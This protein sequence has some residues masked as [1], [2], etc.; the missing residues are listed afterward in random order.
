MKKFLSMALATAMTM[1]MASVAFAAETTLKVMI[2]NSG[3][4]VGEACYYNDDKDADVKSVMYKADHQFV[5]GDTVYYPLIGTEP[6]TTGD[7]TNNAFIVYESD[8]V[9]GLKFKADWQM[10]KD[11]VK[12]VSLVKKKTDSTVLSA[13]GATPTT[14]A[15]GKSYAYYMAVSIKDSLTTK[16]TDI[17]GKISFDKSAT[18]N[19]N[20]NADGK[21]NDELD[22][23]THSF[24]VNLSVAYN[25]KGN[26]KDNDYTVEKD[27]KTFY[28]DNENDEEEIVLIDSDTATF[29]VDTRGQ[30]KIVM[31]ANNDFNAAISAKY[32]N[33][34]LDFI[35][36]EAS[37][38]FNKIG[39]LR[40]FTPD[41]D[42]YLYAL[43]KDGNITNAKAKYDSN[44]ECYVMR[45]RTLG[46]FVLSDTELDVKTPDVEVPEVKPDVTPKP[47]NKPFNPGT[48]AAC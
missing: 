12:N 40:V 11:Y 44:D 34:N 43:D 22:Y 26:N 35:N 9:K 39:T 41:G 5:Y 8:A 32:P 42:K 48:G 27:R 23:K 37:D 25:P 31:S 15:G 4:V 45:T 10:G 46:S 24:D 7:P 2:D 38:S 18:K 19:K 16:T 36:V 47:E 33:A 20:I 21:Y 13:V 17:Y 14:L 29:T 6:S 1:S 30:G 28:F 3:N